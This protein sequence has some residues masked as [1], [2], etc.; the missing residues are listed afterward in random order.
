VEHDFDVSRMRDEASWRVFQ[1]YSLHATGTARNDSC[2]NIGGLVDIRQHAPPLNRCMRFADKGTC[3]RH[4]VGRTPCRF[5]QEQGCRRFMGCQSNLWHSAAPSARTVPPRPFAVPF[6]H[7]V[8]PHNGSSHVA[9]RRGTRQLVRPTP[10]WNISTTADRWVAA[11]LNK[12]V[13]SGPMVVSWLGLEGTGHHGICATLAPRCSSHVAARIYHLGVG[14]FSNSRSTN[15]ALSQGYHGAGAE[16]D[17]YDAQPVTLEGNIND[18]HPP[19]PCF[20]LDPVLA[21]LMVN[22]VDSSPDKVSWHR[23]RL[24]KRMRLYKS[25]GL[26]ET[27]R[28]HFQ[29][30]AGKGDGNGTMLSF[31]DESAAAR[32]WKR[33]HRGWRDQIY[34]GISWARPDALELAR[35]AEANGVDARFVWL[36]RDPLSLV[37]SKYRRFN[38][39]TGEKGVKLSLASMAHV[40]LVSDALLRWTLQR[41]H[42]AF[43]REMRYERASQQADELADF[44]MMNGN[45]TTTPTQGPERPQGSLNESNLASTADAPDR[46]GHQLSFAENMRLRWRPGSSSNQLIPEETR[47]YLA[48][49]WGSIGL[50]DVD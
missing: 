35:A 2:R 45:S 33:G 19:P 40:A 20:V 39:K 10:I 12:T 34:E 26:P 21:D 17:D 1:L 29:C 37:L 28:I 22:M 44:L 31:P 46:R 15:R 47:R 48:H 43:I 41:L 42:P 6:A 3:E 11:P 18:T 49:L 25:A 27:L 50:G 16:A 36:T 9:A 7:T 30:S 13:Y 23:N 14:N 24:R 4:R 5:A 8:R 38:D 32:G